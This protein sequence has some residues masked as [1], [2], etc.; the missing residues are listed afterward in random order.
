MILI[1]NKE[2]DIPKGWTKCDGGVH[3]RYVLDRPNNKLN[4]GKTI[5]D[6]SVFSV[7]SSR[8]FAFN[9]MRSATKKIIIA[10]KIHDKLIIND[11][12][13]FAFIF[14]S[15]IKIKKNSNNKIK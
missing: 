12:F 5:P 15:Q 1:W 8:L 2:S 3:V 7:D 14:I 10:S 13:K 9:F 11:I 6:Y 4:N